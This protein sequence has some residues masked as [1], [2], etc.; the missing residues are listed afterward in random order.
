MT[1]TNKFTFHFSLFTVLFFLCVL[2]GELSADITTKTWVFAS[3]TEGLADAGNHANVSF[4][5]EAGDGN[6]SGAAEFST[7]TKALSAA[8][9]FARKAS[10]GDTWETWGVPAGATVTQVQVTAWDEKLTAN[11]KLTSHTL[12]ARVIGSGGGTVHSAGDLLDVA[13]GTTVDA[14]WQAGAAGTARAVDAGSQAASTDVRLELQWV[15]TTSG[16]GG[17]ADVQQDL[18][19]IELTITYTP[20]GGGPPKSLRRMLITRRPAAPGGPGAATLLAQV[21]RRTGDTR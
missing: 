16:G 14:S 6:P 7:S 18:D 19:N 13:M 9:E 4:A 15:V 1:Q 20:G 3:D 8:T 21:P 5:H 2:C 11:T 10:T 17:S 12:K